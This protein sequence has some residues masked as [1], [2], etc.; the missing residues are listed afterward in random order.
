MERTKVCQ[1]YLDVRT[2]CSLI[3]KLFVLMS[4]LITRRA[5]EALHSHGFVHADLKP[6]NVMWS[7]S[8]GC[9]KLLDFG[10]TFHTAES[11]LHQVQTKGYQAPEAAEWNRYKEEL[12]R[13]RLRAGGGGKKRK[14]QQTAC[15]N[16]SAT[17]E[18]EELEEEE[19]VEQEEEEVE[20]LKQSDKEEWPSESSGVFTASEFSQASP[21]VTG[22]TGVSAK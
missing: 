4:Q 8:D 17:V 1:G 2:A 18:E 19:L 21:P 6:A 11:E 22:K 12:K 7:G 14:M 13:E 9:F 15:L 10:L 5:L 3:D 16:L 20:A